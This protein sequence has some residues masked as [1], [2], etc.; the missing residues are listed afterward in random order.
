MPKGTLPSAKDGV[1]YY[2][3]LGRLS[4][5]QH[6]LKELGAHL[7]TAPHDTEE[8]HSRVRGGERRAEAFQS[9]H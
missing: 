8:T 2:S 3:V 6:S 7:I 4:E 9:D 1:S 5:S